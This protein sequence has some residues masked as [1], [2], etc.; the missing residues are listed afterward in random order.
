MSVS[1]P[2]A[3]RTSLGSIAIL[4]L[5]RPSVFNVLSVAMMSAIQTELDRLAADDSISVVIIRAEGSGFCAGHDLK[6]M[7][8]RRSDSDSGKAF[9]TDLFSQCTRLM[10]AI[11]ALPQPVI[12]EVQG[13]AVAAGC[14]LVATCDM[15]V[16]SENAKFGV[17]GIDVGFFC[18]TPSVALSRNIGRKMAMELLTT[19]EMLTANEG[20]DV[21][22]VNLVVG[23]ED[24]NSATMNL[25]RKVSSK[26]RNVLALGKKAFQTQINLPREEAYKAMEAVMVENLMMDESIEGFSAFIEKRPPKWPE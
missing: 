9:F 24:L 21:G 8:G 10:T 22:L 1:P 3:Y 23:R 14:Q 20:V 5:N 17:N 15:A 26:P 6:E 13:T 18:S 25:A 7:H 19:G 2:Y 11:T 12:A 16:A 4:H